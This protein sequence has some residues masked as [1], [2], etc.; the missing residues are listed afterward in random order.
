MEPAAG[1]SQLVPRAAEGVP[2]RDAVRR[3]AALGAAVAASVV[4]LTLAV[5]V[6]KWLRA[7]L[8]SR[9]GWQRR[10]G[11]ARGRRVVIPET[12]CACVK[13]RAVPSGHRGGG[14]AGW[15]PGPVWLA[16]FPPTGFPDGVFMARVKWAQRG[17]GEKKLF[18][19]LE[20]FEKCQK[21]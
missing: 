17:T 12:E 18:K 19:N 3:R 4:I 8:G 13:S 7:C 15:V 2:A 11:V 6:G 10:P 9:P 1:E 16:R 14:R 20:K 21:V 5:L